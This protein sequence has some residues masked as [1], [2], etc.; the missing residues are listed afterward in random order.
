MENSKSE[1]QRLFRRI[2][3]RAVA[4]RVVYDEASGNYVPKYSFDG[5]KYK[6]FRTPHVMSFPSRQDAI[7][8]VRTLYECSP[9][10]AEAKCHDRYEVE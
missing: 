7:W 3:K 2:T 4:Y 9:K 10:M 1:V 8:F 6:F 5:E